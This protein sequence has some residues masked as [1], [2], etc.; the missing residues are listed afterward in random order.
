MQLVR[1]GVSEKS[2]VLKLVNKGF[3]AA[4]VWKGEEKQRVNL[5]DCWIDYKCYASVYI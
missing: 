3:S 2:A 1:G 4:L 5:C